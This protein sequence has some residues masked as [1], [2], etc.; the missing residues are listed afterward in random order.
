ML[1]TDSDPELRV[2]DPLIR[3]LHWLTL[4]LVAVTFVLAVSIDL[5][6]KSEAA[7]LVQMHRS[8]GVS[9]WVV[10]LGR[11]VWRQFSR[12]PNWPADMSQLM[13]FTAHWSEY[14]LYALLL[15]QPVLGLLHTNAHGDRVNL[16]F[17]GHLP[18][19]MSR[20]HQLATQLM[21]AHKTVGL[22]L[23]GLIAVHAS[24]ALYHHFWRRD[25]TLRAML[26]QGWSDVHPFGNRSE[27]VST[28]YGLSSAKA[29]DRQ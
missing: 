9:V 22:L 21:A 26:P 29:N 1:R 17:L 19:V 8:F 27:S 4:F 18:A 2:F 15:T 13:R 11:L 28:P 5:T 14:A 23:L 3:F 6:P 12:F 16:F 7:V 20:D 25:D 10:T 24:A